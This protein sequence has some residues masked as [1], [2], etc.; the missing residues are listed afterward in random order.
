MMMMMT[1]TKLTQLVPLTHFPK[2]SLKTAANCRGPQV[3]LPEELSKNVIVLSCDS[4]AKGGVCDV[5]VVGTNHSSKESSKQVEDIIKFLKP[6][7][8]FLELC[9]SRQHILYR[10]KLKVPTE[11]DMIAMWKKKRN[12]FAILHSWYIAERANELEVYPGAEF[13]SGYREAKKYGGKVVL[14][15]RQQHITLKRTWRKLPL[16]HII[17]LFNSPEIN[18][19]DFSSISD[20]AKRRQILSELLPTVMETIVHERDKYMSHTLLRVASQNRSVVAV[21]GRGHLQGIKKNWKQPIKM[22]DLVI[23]PPPKLPIPVMRLFAYVGI[24]V[25][26]VTIITKTYL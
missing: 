6:E 25:A 26:G 19:S 9:S 1:R 21:V 4:T 20:Y 11:E 7:T 17:R 2:C 12:I 23:I 8:V 13:R 14:G 18:F 5:Y 3:E 24:V 10:E 22:Q 15:D 16:K